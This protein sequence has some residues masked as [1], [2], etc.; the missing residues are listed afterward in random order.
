MKKR[1]YCIGGKKEGRLDREEGG[2][3]VEK[4]EH[5]VVTR[6]RNGEE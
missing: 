6:E 1:E 4:V 2:Q 5:N 3:S